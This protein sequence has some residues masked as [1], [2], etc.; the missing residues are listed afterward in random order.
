MQQHGVP[1]KP[2]QQLNRAV[3]GQV[4]QVQAGPVMDPE[5][6]RLP[7]QPRVIEPT[8]DRDRTVKVLKRDESVLKGEVGAAPQVTARY[9]HALRPVVLVRA[10][11]SCSSSRSAARIHC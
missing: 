4:G 11:E 5:H 7:E 8:A 6:V 10:Q 2:I 3:V 9:E 1:T